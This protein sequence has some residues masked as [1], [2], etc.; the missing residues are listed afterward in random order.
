[1]AGGMGGM[2][3]MH[4]GTSAAQPKE[5]YPSLMSLP[6]LTPEKRAEVERQADERMQAGTALMS[7]GLDRLSE[8]TA[9]D[10]YAAMQEATAQMREGLALFESGV[11]AR[12]A[13]AEGKA[14]RDIALQ[15]FKGEMNLSAPAAGPDA[16][17]GLFGLSWFHVF[18]M[19][20]LVAFAAV[21]LGMYFHKMR[22]ASELLK[23]LTSGAPGPEAIS[24]PVAP[25]QSVAPSRVEA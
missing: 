14:P 7:Q 17:G 16:P 11:A 23:R 10:D 13:L 19:V 9:K 4:G 21:L 2:E 6:E 25:P 3:G 1:M 8:A 15:W 18:V 5:S 12:R 24:P 20:I 22:R